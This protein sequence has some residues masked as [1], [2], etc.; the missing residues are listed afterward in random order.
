M[1]AKALWMNGIVMAVF[2][3]ANLRATAQTDQPKLSYEVVSIKPHNSADPGGSSQ[4]L[5]DGFRDANTSIS[6]L[7]H[8]AYELYQESQVE[9]L[10]DW[11]KNDRFDIEA[12]ED[13]KTAEYLKTLSRKERG[14]KEQELLQS[15]LADRCQLKAHLVIREM[16]LYDLVIAKK[17][18][19]M[20][21]V[22][23]DTKGRSMFGREMI[24][25]HGGTARSLATYFQN[26]L[27]RI[28]VDKTGLDDK[29]FDFKLEWAE[30]NGAEANGDAGPSIY[31][32]LEEQLGLKLVPDK[33]PVPVLVI[34]HIEKPTPN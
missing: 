29:K 2:A 21:E 32:A 15:L 26:A 18:L 24:D 13:E 14:Q 8:G 7:I 17:G 1:P 23:A 3:I 20:K 9:G 34:D 27:G 11:A 16:P 19:K 6:N 28:I 4:S 22:P 33:G 10:P 12:K 31:T 25:A 5:A 30:E